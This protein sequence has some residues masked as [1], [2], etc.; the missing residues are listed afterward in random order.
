MNNDE[1]PIIVLCTCPDQATAQNLATIL[2]EEYCA[3]CINIIAGINSIYRWQGQIERAT[4]YL[5]IIKTQSILYKKL[6]TTIIKHHP[7]QLP[8]I[9]ALP[10]AQ[11]LPTYLNW[12]KTNLLPKIKL[13]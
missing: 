5:L 9:I 10:I 4:E 1:H 6:E 7:Y 12:I 11:G 2:I 3:A 8:E 13:D